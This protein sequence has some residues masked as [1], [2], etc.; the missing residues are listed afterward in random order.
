MAGFG[1][2]SHLVHVVDGHDAQDPIVS[3]E[4]QQVRELLGT[5]VA[6]QVQ[7]LHHVLRLD[8]GVSLV[9]E[10]ILLRPA[11]GYRIQSRVEIAARRVDSTRTWRP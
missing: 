5:R 6:D 8:A 4:P 1:L 7:V 11:N 2:F 9:A 3:V 10:P